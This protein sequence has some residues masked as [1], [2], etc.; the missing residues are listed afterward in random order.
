MQLQSRDTNTALR[1]TE[2]QR[3]AWLVAALPS[4]VLRNMASNCSVTRGGV[5]SVPDGGQVFPTRFITCALN[6]LAN[7]L[8]RGRKASN[9]QVIDCLD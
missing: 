9:C 4:G 6:R 8:V 3:E 1:P 5:V 2:E 7:A